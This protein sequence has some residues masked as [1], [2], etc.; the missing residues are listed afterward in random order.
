MLAPRGGLARPH[1]QEC[2][3]G[4]RVVCEPRWGQWHCYGQVPQ[5]LMECSQW[6]GRDIRM[7]PRSLVSSMAQP[8]FNLGQ[9]SLVPLEILMCAAAGMKTG[10]LTFL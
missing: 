6:R 8:S 3:A 10:S 9:G 7:D 2:R 5:P 1:V 4:R